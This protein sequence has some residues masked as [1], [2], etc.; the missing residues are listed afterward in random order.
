M[1][2]NNTISA[3]IN[4]TNNG[5]NNMNTAEIN[6][7]NTKTAGQFAIEFQSSGYGGCIPVING[8]KEYSLMFGY[9][10]ES[11]KQ[12]CIDLITKAALACDGDVFAMRSYMMNATRISAEGIQPEDTVEVQG[13]ELLVN[14]TEKK[15][16]DETRELANL[17]DMTSEM[18]N[19]VIKALL[20]ERAN[21]KIT[22]EIMAYDAYVEELDDEPDWND[23][24]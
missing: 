11:D 23:Y 22:E 17:D 20:V 6:T 5:G 7:K 2:T 16:Y 24:F 15:I 14:Y 21:N 19:E 10:S 8:N 13:R 18:S 4:N 12:A 3:T 1:A 9:V